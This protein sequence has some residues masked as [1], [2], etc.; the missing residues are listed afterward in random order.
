MESPPY[1]VG[2]ALDGAA[3]IKI[4]GG[5]DETVSTVCTGEKFWQSS[6]LLISYERETS[7]SGLPYKGRSPS[8]LAARLGPLPQGLTSIPLRFADCTAD[9]KSGWQLH[10]R[11]L[12]SPMAA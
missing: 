2:P 12:Y 11:A 10:C 7:A 8:R 9:Q 6:L 4:A 5:G 3:S 1:L